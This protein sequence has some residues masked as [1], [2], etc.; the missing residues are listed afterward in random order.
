MEDV[1]RFTALEVASHYPTLVILGDPGSGKTTFLNHL[2]AM[3]AEMHLNPKSKPPQQWPHGALLPVRILLRELAITLEMKNAAK[4]LDEGCE[5]SQR[6]LSLLVNEH[7]D[8]HLSDYEATDFVDALH[9]AI[10]EGQ[11]LIVFDGLDEAPPSQ[12]ILV[13]S[14][15][16]SLNL[17]VLRPLTKNRLMPLLTVGMM[18]SC[19]SS[20]LQKMMSKRK[21]Q[22]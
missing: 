6:K 1:H 18:H 17:S 8:E 2:L 21:K 12:R 14:A 9:Q 7:I 13:R 3:L 10:N 22:V 11:C 16:E 20:N 19:K 5:V 4:I 15:V